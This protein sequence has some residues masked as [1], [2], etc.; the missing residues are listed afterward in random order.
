MLF[1]PRPYFK[2]GSY[3]LNEKAAHQS[4]EKASYYATSNYAFSKSHINGLSL[5]QFSKKRTHLIRL[6]NPKLDKCTMHQLR[7]QGCVLPHSQQD[8]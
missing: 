2:C 1:L 3:Q 8:T 4:N 6:L 7:M 5:K